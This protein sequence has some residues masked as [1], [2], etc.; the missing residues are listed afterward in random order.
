M[1]ED[2]NAELAHRLS[3]RAPGGERRWEEIIEIF[4]AFV[5]AAVAI[6][7]AWSGYQAARWDGRQAFEYA[8]SSRLH[9]EAGVAATAGGQQ[10]L[11]DVSTFNTW[12]VAHQQGNHD[13]ANI[14]VRRFSP[15][16]RRAFLAWLALDP[17]D[18]RRAPPGPIFMPEYHNP[19]LAQAQQLNEQ[20]TAA[21]ERG[22][23]DR[24]VAEQYVRLTVLFATVLFLIALSQR[25]K[26]RSVRIGVLAVAVLLMGTGFV[27]LIA[28]RHA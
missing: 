15:A 3:E 17:F 11:L 4:E 16:Y 8:T 1:A 13:L 23:Q 27:G 19:L 5:L 28:Y 18:D 24:E 10:R 14:Y 2:L 22:T 20:A 26:Q 9:V 7:T 25:F 6:A 12:I 21:F